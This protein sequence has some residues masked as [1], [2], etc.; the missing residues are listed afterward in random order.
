M[1]SCQFFSKYKQ[2][3]KRITFSIALII[4][5]I[6][7]VQ[8]LSI[9]VDTLTTIFMYLSSISIL[10]GLFIINKLQKS[11]SKK[12]QE[13]ENFKKLEEDVKTTTISTT[14]DRLIKYETS[15]IEFYESQIHLFITIKSKTLFYI[16]IKIL[17]I[18]SLLII[19]ILLVISV[20]L[21]SG[22][23][24][25]ILTHIISLFQFVFILPLIFID[26]YI[27]SGKRIYRYAKKS[28]NY[29]KKRNKLIYYNSKL[30]NGN[31]ESHK[32]QLNEINTR[33]DDFNKIIT[34][35]SNYIKEFEIITILGIFINI[36]LVVSF[37]LFLIPLFYLSILYLIY[38]LDH[39]KK[40][41]EIKTTKLYQQI[42]SDLD[43]LAFSK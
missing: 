27:N 17:L 42:E 15:W 35:F 30:I 24:N 12:R 33:I 13:V 5:Y 16:I 43:L 39:I 20:K 8:I 36:F 18:I 22:E 21:V 26:L 2:K 19:I 11:F 31:F 10:L 9:F 4:S 38:I 23:I 7:I 34:P 6:I 28:S 14:L 41:H 37:E 32:I 25:V 40:N 29:I 3:I 1:K